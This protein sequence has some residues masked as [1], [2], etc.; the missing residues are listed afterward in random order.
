MVR[1]RPSIAILELSKSLARRGHRISFV[2]APRNIQ[3]LPIIPPDLATLID[4]IKFHCLIRK[5]YHPDAESTADVPLQQ[6]AI[7]DQGR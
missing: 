2:S 6:A 4:F 7:H 1:I 3:R 5:I